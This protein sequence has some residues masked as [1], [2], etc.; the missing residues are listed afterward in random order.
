MLPP[1]K[2]EEKVKK[3]NDFIKWPGLF[4]K[5][6][7]IRVH[8]T[9]GDSYVNAKVRWICSYFKDTAVELNVIKNLSV[10]GLFWGFMSTQECTSVRIDN[11]RTTRVNN[12]CLLKQFEGDEEKRLKEEPFQVK[13]GFEFWWCQHLMTLNHL[14]PKGKQHYYLYSDLT[15][16]CKGYSYLKLYAGT[17]V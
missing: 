16:L 17:P 10:L 4:F 11:V 8:I 15:F 2:C 1:E 14:G 7:S 6:W 13:K 9:F 3:L 5:Q 12:I